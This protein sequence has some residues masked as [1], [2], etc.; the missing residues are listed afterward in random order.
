MTKSS[1]IPVEGHPNFCRDKNTGVIV[2]T[3][4]SSFA[5]YLQRNSQK[6]KN[7]KPSRQEAEAAVRTLLSFVGEDADR[8]GLIETPK[9]VVRAYEDWFSGYND[10]P[11]EVLSKTFDELE[12]YDE[13]IMP[14]SYTHLTLPTSDLV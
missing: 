5:A 1:L 4:S 9:R 2:I 11:K 10:D 6:K 13:I 7:I 12:G 8:P 14:V 3:D